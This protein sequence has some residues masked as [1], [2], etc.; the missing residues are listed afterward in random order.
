MIFPEDL[1][2]TE[3]AINAL[4][5]FS[6]PHELAG[7]QWRAEHCGHNFIPSQCPYAECGF[8]ESLEIALKYIRMFKS[9]AVDM[10]RMSNLPAE[11][12]E[13]YTAANIAV[14]LA[15]EALQRVRS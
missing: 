10:Q 15:R 9:L 3:R 5:V 13:S 8:R 2:S 6:V 12:R 4:L 11:T 14:E 7:E 1:D